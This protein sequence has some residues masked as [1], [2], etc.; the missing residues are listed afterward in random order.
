[1][2]EEITGNERFPQIFATTRKKIITGLTDLK[3]RKPTEWDTK[4]KQANRIPEALRTRRN[5]E[6]RSE[7]KP[8]ATNEGT[9]CKSIW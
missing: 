8:Q 7:L 6:R 4:E 5:K 1:M 9:D 3:K 2:G